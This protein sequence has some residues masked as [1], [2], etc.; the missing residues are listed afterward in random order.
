MNE[1][2][3]TLSL[4][5]LDAVSDGDAGKIIDA[6]IRRVVADLR[7]NPK[8]AAARKVVV[9]LALTSSDAGTRWCAKVTAKVVLPAEG[10]KETL[11][12]FEVS[13]ASP[14]ALFNPRSARNPDQMV[15]DF[16]PEPEDEPEIKP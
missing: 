1:N 3:I 7:S 12:L 11:G 9:E 2:L 4:A 10:T 16:V 13:A 15:L 8:I 14:E 6:A 5:N